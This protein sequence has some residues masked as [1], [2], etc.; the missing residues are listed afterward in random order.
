MRPRARRC[1]CYTYKDKECVYYCHLDI[2]WINTP[3]I[4]CSKSTFQVALGQYSEQGLAQ[5]HKECHGRELVAQD[6]QE[7]GA[8]G[9]CHMDCPTTEAA[10]EAKDPQA[11]PKALP[12]PRLDV[13]V[14]MLRMNSVCSFAEEWKT[15]E[16]LTLLK[17]RNKNLNCNS[18]LRW[19][20]S[21]LQCDASGEL[22]NAPLPLQQC[23]RRAR[24]L[25]ERLI[26]A[27]L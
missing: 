26:L 9:L 3:E 6:P 14:W 21:M 25:Q 19:T 23:P 22:S 20:N 7:S 12:S 16:A 24:N 4:S 17:L 27:P 8:G 18:P 13:P 5:E 2:I 15:E 11:R 10:L 1:T